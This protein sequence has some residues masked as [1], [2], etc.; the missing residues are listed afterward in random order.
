MT[1]SW[2]AAAVVC[3]AVCT[4]TQLDAAVLRPSPGLLFGTKA[5]GGWSSPAPAT[6]ATRAEPQGQALVT[7]AGRVVDATTGEPLADVLVQVQ[8]T[9]IVA[10]TG[11]DGRFVLA[12]VAPGETSLYISV[13]GYGLARREATAP[14][15]AGTELVVPLA[16][17]SSAYTEEVK[18]S[19]ETFLKEAMGVPVQQSLDSRELQDLRGVLA[20]DP[21]RA[22]HVLP[23]VATS[24]DFRGEFT[25]RGSDFAHLSVIFEGVANPYLFHTV[26]AVD[27][28][29]SIALINGDVLDSVALLSGAYPQRYGG[30]L[31][32][33][34]EFR[35]REGSRERRQFRGLVSGTA[36]S[37]VAEGPVGTSKRGSWLLSVRRSYLDWLLET[38]D[39]TSTTTFG[40]YDLFGKAVLDVSPRHRF[41]LTAVGGRSQA[42]ESEERPSVNDFRVGVQRAGF[43]AL[44]WRYTPSSS[45]VLTQRLY[46]TAARYANSNVS[47]RELDSGA[48]RDAG[49]RADGSYAVSPTTTV[50]AGV[51]AQ[52]LF[53]D[54]ARTRYTAAGDRRSTT[55]FDRT[56]SRQGA[57]AS[58][59]RRFGT[60]IA[61][62]PGVRLDRWTVVERG[63]IS[64]W[65]QVEWTL[66]ERTRLT[67]GAGR[68]AQAPSAEAQS[69]AS[70]AERLALERATHVD[71]GLERRVSP[72]TR[73]QVSVYQRKESDLVWQSGTEAR[74]VAGRLRVPSPSAPYTNALHGT[75]RGVELLAQ[76]KSAQGLSGWASYSFASSRDTDE[77]SGET[78]DR[79]TGQRHTFNLYAQYRPTS[80]LSLSTKL[81]A[82]DNFPLSGYYEQIGGRYYVAERRNQVR[83]PVYARLDARANYTFN[84]TRRRLTLFIEVVNALGRTNYRPSQASI[85]GRTGQAF[86]TEELFPLL[87]SAGLLIEF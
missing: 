67:F 38:I 62:S 52:G 9:D 23:G 58:V 57:Y 65:L 80:R 39:A 11:A 46:A 74:L 27:D 68:Y 44:G 37:A 76:R 13:V 33:Q 43:V 77:A 78:F 19:G 12:G 24:D 28:S 17:G 31:G 1:H 4:A 26:R 56:T 87:P 7:I 48:D 55:R 45:V 10:L 73:V 40:F 30:R 29:G 49:W 21:G 14:T 34:V 16:R 22:I 59:R 5:A 63:A 66:A 53:E 51:H 6:R 84:L 60:S 18:V 8:G 61:V 64:P 50:D 35:A 69:L 41:E 47:G 54:R 82:G 15:P 20:D 3:F 85:D 72:T 71:L 83:A 79:A 42:N 70:P 36:A 86:P 32:A 75:S 81:R 25:V 2:S